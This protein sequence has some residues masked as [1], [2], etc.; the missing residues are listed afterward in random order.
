M[1][2]VV[3]SPERKSGWR[4][5]FRMNGVFVFTPRMRVSVKALA[6]LSAADWKV[7]AE[8]VTCIAH[9]HSMHN[10]RQYGIAALS[11]AVR[12]LFVSHLAGHL[13]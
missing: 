10:S 5:T 3:A 7:S 9:A 4:N 8:P 2:E 13:H 11:R 1:K 6:T 12:A